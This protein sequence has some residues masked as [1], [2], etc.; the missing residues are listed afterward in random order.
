MI[1]FILNNKKKIPFIPTAALL[2][3]G[4]AQGEWVPNRHRPSQTVE[5]V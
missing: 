2:S 4:P 1:I 3:D 5:E